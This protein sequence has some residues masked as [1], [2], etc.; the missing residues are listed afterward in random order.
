LVTYRE[1]S[2][3]VT[4]QITSNYPDAEVKII[5]KKDYIDIKPAGYTLKAVSS[6]KVNTDIFPI[7]TYKYFEDDPLSSITNAF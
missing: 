3:L 4:Q 5:D 6:G 2:T 1:C 7:K